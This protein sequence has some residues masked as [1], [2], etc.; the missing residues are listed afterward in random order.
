IGPCVLPLHQPDAPARASLARFEVALFREVLG[1]V[2][3]QAPLQLPERILLLG[4]NHP[5]IPLAEE[6]T[7]RW[8]SSK[9]LGPNS[10]AFSS[11]CT[12]R[13]AG[14]ACW[15]AVSSLASCTW[16][17][18]G[19]PGPCSPRLPLSPI[20]LLTST[21]R[22]EST[23]TPS[24]PRPHTAPSAPATGGLIGNGRRQ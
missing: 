19:R 10:S 6:G 18:W 16:A 23:S 17:A 9:K 2:V 7:P 13:C 20:G 11:R 24:M 15:S 12:C 22:P 14:R 8:S 3:Q 21:H 5:A 1:H 4:S